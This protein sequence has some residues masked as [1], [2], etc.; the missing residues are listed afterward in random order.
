MTSR[1]G[2]AARAEDRRVE[3]VLD[4]L[5]GERRIVRIEHDEIGAHARPRSR[6][7]AA[8]APARRRARQRATAVGRPAFATDRRARC[9]GA[10][11]IRCDHSSCRSFGERID[12]RVG[13]AADAEAAARRQVGLA[14]ETCRRRD[15]PRSSARAR[16]PR[17]SRRGP[18]PR[19]R[20]CAS[21]GRRTSARPRP[22]CA[23]SHS[24]GRM[25]LQ[26]IAVVDF[27]RLLRRVDV[28]RALAAAPCARPSSSSSAR[29][30][31]QAVRRDADA[32]SRSA[33][34]CAR[35]ASSN[36]ANV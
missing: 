34:A 26:A 32:C 14:L 24:T 10:A 19:A 12:E 15:R 5:L 20:S 7:S 33:A 9:A 31:A 3:H 35:R 36:C 25:R 30:R 1:T 16:R 18:R 6:R 21:H 2:R 17:R 23:S 28:D 29:D 22:P 11:R 8:R 13:V 27:A 4:R